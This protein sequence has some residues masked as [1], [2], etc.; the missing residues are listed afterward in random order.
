MIK[1]CQDQSTPNQE[2]LESAHGY[3]MGVLKKEIGEQFLLVTETVPQS[4]RQFKS[5]KQI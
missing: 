4:K 5:L 2:Q 3:I 1:H